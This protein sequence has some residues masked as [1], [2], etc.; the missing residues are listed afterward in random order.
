MSVG[1]SLYRKPSQYC[2]SQCSCRP[3]AV[4]NKKRAY[5]LRCHLYVRHYINGLIYIELHYFLTAPVRL[6]VKRYVVAGMTGYGM[7]HF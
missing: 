4:A 6:I 5:P 3:P 7:I 2:A 1:V